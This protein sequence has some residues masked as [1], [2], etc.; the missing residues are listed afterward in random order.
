LAE[1]LPILLLNLQKNKAKQK[2]ILNTNGGLTWWH[3]HWQLRCTNW[4]MSIRT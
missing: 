2:I 1:T 3:W 4:S